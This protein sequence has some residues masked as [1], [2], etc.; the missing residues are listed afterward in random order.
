MSFR[1]YKSFRFPGYHF[2]LTSTWVHEL[3]VYDAPSREKSHEFLSQISS[4][5]QDYDID[6]RGPDKGCL[7][8][9]FEVHW[10]RLLKILSALDFY[11]SHPV[12]TSPVYYLQY[13]EKPELRCILKVKGYDFS[14]I[15]GAPDELEDILLSILSRFTPIRE[16]EFSI[17]LSCTIQDARDFLLRSNFTLLHE[18]ISYDPH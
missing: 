12:T 8:I 18:D 11:D 17:R 15:S 6:C 4:W 5:M 10:G 7:Q 2:T 3:R 9:P 16:G 1:Y 13:N 14:C